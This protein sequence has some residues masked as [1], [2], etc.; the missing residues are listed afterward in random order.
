MCETMWCWCFLLSYQP[1]AVYAPK[2]YSDWYI[3]SSIELSNRGIVANFIISIHRYVISYERL[4]YET[5]TC[6]L[7]NAQSKVRLCSANHRAGYFS[8]LACDWLS[9]AWAYSEQDTENRPW[10]PCL[11]YEMAVCQVG[12]IWEACLPL[13]PLMQKKLKFSAR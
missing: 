1:L 3:S 7:L 13:K 6:F 4:L 2:P 9:I 12:L 8:N 5:R 10:L 11:L